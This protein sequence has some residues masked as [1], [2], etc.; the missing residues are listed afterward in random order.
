MH[1]TSVL[2]VD[3]DHAF[4]EYVA[5][6]LRG[7]DFNV[8]AVECGAQLLPYLTSGAAL[9]SVIVMDVLLPDSDGLEL[10]GRMQKAG[11]DVPVIMLSGAGHV[12]TVVEAMKLGA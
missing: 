7:R 8:D 11:I 9:P 6:L 10:I 5:T 1:R 3:D 4:R 12:R 2:L